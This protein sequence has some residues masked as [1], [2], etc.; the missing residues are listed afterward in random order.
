LTLWAHTARIRAPREHHA[1][2]R[3]TGRGF[4]TVS[5]QVRMRAV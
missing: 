3:P 5:E 1:K 4:A 2:P